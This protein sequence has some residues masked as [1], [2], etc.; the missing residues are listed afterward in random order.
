MHLTEEQLSKIIEE[1]FI[2]LINEE[3][4]DEKLFDKLKNFGKG[5]ISKL[6]KP[7]P[8]ASAG[9]GRSFARYKVPQ[10]Q[11]VAV[12]PESEPNT[13]LVP[14]DST[15][16]STDVVDISPESE[17]TKVGKTTASVQPRLALPSGEKTQQQ[18]DD[19]VGELPPTN[20]LPLQLPPPQ[21][22]GIADDYGSLQKSVDDTAYSKLLG[23]VQQQFF[24]TPRLQNL[25]QPEKNKYSKDINSVLK[26]LVSKNRVLSNSTIVPKD[27]LREKTVQEA[28][29]REKIP[30]AQQ[31]GLEPWY[32]DG[33]INTTK[34]HFSG[35]INNKLIEFVITTLYKD[36]RIAISRRMYNKLLHTSDP[37]IAKQDLEDIENSL[38]EPSIKKESKS[39]NNFYN[40]WKK[41]TG[42]KI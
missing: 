31:V 26:Y 28:E 30:S 4:I 9:V 6:T 1:E 5:I 29:E 18:P 21:L 34:R 7:T 24:D 42:V 33:L 38:D 37:R 39:Y 3:E 10:K 40:N 15:L 32:I 36:G 8:N 2:N 35:T 13:A 11:P 14:R 20:K 23:R 22:I 12:E 25:P 27:I 17:P 41:Y 19:I 16:P